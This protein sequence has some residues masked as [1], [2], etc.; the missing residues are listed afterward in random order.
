MP[1]NIIFFYT[2]NLWL[3]FCKSNI[4]IVWQQLEALEWTGLGKIYSLPLHNIFLPLFPKLQELY[5]SEAKIGDSCLQILG[6]FCLELRYRKIRVPLYITLTS[7]TLNFIY[8]DIWMFLIVKLWQMMGS[9]D[10]A[11]MKTWKMKLGEWGNANLFTPWR[12][13]I[14]KL[15]K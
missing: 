3:Q 14:P 5:L 6:T 4:S 2:L 13:S 9:K 11:L 15:P 7:L 1:R 12:W 8:V 10:C